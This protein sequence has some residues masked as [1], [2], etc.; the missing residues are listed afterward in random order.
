MLDSLQKDPVLFVVRTP[1][2][3]W[4]FQMRANH[5]LVKIDH[6]FLVATNKCSLNQ[7]QNSIGPIVGMLTV[8]GNLQI[9]WNLDSQIPLKSRLLQDVVVH[10]V[11][12][13][14]ISAS[15]MHN[16]AF[17]FVELHLPYSSP[18]H[19][20][21]QVLLYTDGILSRRN[22]S[23][24]FGVICKFQDIAGDPS[25]KIVDE[26]QEEDRSQDWSLRH[27]AAH[28]APRR[29]RSAKTNSLPTIP[30]PRLDPWKHLAVY[31]MTSYLGYQTLMR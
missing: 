13:L 15:K 2:R 8:D 14:L 18:F 17:T 12:E 22:L 4:V 23:E 11:W 19:Q 27:S 25:I 16:L 1:R 28:S 3:D 5:S 6:R 21:V 7:S 26:D 20:P 9:R 10:C 30:Q 31:S 29:R 24:Q